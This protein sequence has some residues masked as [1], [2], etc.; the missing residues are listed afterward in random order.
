MVLISVL[1]HNHK[2][3]TELQNPTFSMTLMLLDS[4]AVMF[5]HYKTSVKTLS[6]VDKASACISVAV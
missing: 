4:S 3:I 1:C 2:D 5:E 6:G